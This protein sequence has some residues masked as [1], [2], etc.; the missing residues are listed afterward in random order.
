MA[1][2]FRFVR[3][4]KPFGAV[5]VVKPGLAGVQLRWRHP[6]DLAVL[7]HPGGP[8]ANPADDA[9]VGA[10][11]EAEFVDVGVAALSPIGRDVMHLRAVGADGAARFGA[12][13]ITGN[14]H[15]PLRRGS[16][17]LGAEQIQG[18]SRGTVEHRQVVIGVA[19]QPDHIGD[20][21][22]GATAGDTDPGAGFQV[23]QG[24]ADD[25]RN[26]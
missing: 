16:D 10:A 23:L 6:F 15:D 18:R 14:Q 8:A 25:D 19:G 22:D 11:R 4:Q 5:I 2:R 24:G 13:T 21:H 26:R 7:V 20:R 1:Q 12:S 3:P 17:A 9:V